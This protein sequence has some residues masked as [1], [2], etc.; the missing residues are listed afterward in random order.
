MT[1][2]QRLRL[3]LAAAGLV[4]LLAACGGG[5]DSGEPTNTAPVLTAPPTTSAALQTTSTEASGAVA[6]AVDSAQRMVTLDASLSGNN[7]LPVGNS[8]SSPLSWTRTALSAER[9]QALAVRSLTCADFF[10]STACTGSWSIDTNAANSAT[11]FPAGTY[12][13]LQFN[14]LQGSFGGSPLSINGTLRA[15]FLTPFDPNA[16]STAG[17]SFQLT[18]TNLSGMAEGT[19]FGPI[20]A[21]AL[22]VHDGM[23][24]ETVTIDGQRIIGFDNL[25]VTNADNYSLPNLQLRRAHWA[26]ATG[27]VDVSFSNWSV[28]NGRPIV[29]SA[30]S[31][32][33][34]GGSIS[35]SVMSSSSSAVVYAATATVNGVTVYYTV[36]ATYPASGGAPS[37]VAVTST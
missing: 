9:E 18:F 11:A 24:V 27:Y 34:T 29:G 7:V 28:V 4:T 19:S 36:T 37:Y 23:G 25:T 5:G 12:A 10:S 1:T 32:A 21:V 22:Y 15:D 20:N 30:V 16:A 26:A 17:L 8:V 35:I 13:S 2:M 31:I 3:A 6:A 14:N 33:A